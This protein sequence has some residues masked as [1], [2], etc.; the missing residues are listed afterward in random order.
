MFDFFITRLSLM[1]VKLAVPP[2]ALSDDTGARLANSTHAKLR[3][4]V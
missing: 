3:V 4:M 1:A 2:G